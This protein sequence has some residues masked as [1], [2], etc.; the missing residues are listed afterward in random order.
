M[1]AS[2]AHGDV[3]LGTGGPN[4]DS[5]NGLLSD[6]QQSYGQV[7]GNEITLPFAGRITS[8]TV[9]GLYYNYKNYTNT[10]PEADNFTLRFHNIVGGDPDESV[11]F[12]QNLGAG[13]RTFTGEAF[14]DLKIYKY[15]FQNLNIDVAQG[16]TLLSIINDTDN[17]QTDGYWHWVSANDWGN[18]WWRRE[19]SQ[20]TGQ[21]ITFYW[22]KGSVYDGDRAFELT[23]VPVPAP[24]AALLA[25][26]GLG[27]AGWVK[28]RVA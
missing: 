6:F 23:V 10:P 18:T 27:M 17:P 19:K 8:I 22:T 13:I 21:E 9:W 24:G 4:Y 14:S 26:I 28:R 11:A 25:F 15:E 12:E 3:T 20:P 7:V 1:L 5:V 2:A 16:T